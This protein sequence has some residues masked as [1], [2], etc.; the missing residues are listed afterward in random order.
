MVDYYFVIAGAVSDLPSKND[1]ARHAIYERARVA[2]HERLCTYDPPLSDVELINERYKLEVA[3]YKVEEDLLLGVM[4]GFVKDAASLSFTSAVKDYVRSVG[5]KLNDSMA[6][7]RGHLSSIETTK[8]IPSKADII[9]RLAQ[10]LAF[11]QKT[12]LKAKDIGR[13]IYMS[14]FR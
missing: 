10:G 4:R 6:I 3:I 13:R 9:A 12:L 7:M 8:V 1:E 5:D 11:V 2:L 14:T